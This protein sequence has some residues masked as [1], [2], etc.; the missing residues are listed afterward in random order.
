M[1]NFSIRTN[2]VNRVVIQSSTELCVCAE[3][4]VREARLQQVTC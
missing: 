3:E 4:S 2:K 1:E